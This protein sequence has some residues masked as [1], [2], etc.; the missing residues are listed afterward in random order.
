[1]RT[2]DPASPCA[3]TSPRGPAGDTD[4]SPASR[5]GRSR[6]PLGLQA[7]AGPHVPRTGPPW[8][9]APCTHHPRTCSDPHAHITDRKTE[10]ARRG[11]ASSPMSLSRLGGT[12]FTASSGDSSG[13]SGAWPSKPPC[14]PSALEEALGPPEGC[15]PSPEGKPAWSRGRVSCVPGRWQVPG[16]PPCPRIPADLS[17]PLTPQPGPSVPSGPW[18]RASVLLCLDFP[19]PPPSVRKGGHLPNLARLQNEPAGGVRAQGSQ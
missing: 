10:A 1:M 17:W 4:Q 6:L 16:S 3:D 8:R 19:F 11:E 5:G 2:Q 7:T 18:H 14:A 13:S 9:P 15:P 12:G